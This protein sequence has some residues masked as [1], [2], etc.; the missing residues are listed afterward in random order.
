MVDLSVPTPVRMNF[1]ADTDRDAGNETI[2]LVALCAELL[3]Y[4][5]TITC[6]LITSIS[7]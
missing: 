2:L 7:G 1:R 5:K 6:D 4:D 3:Q